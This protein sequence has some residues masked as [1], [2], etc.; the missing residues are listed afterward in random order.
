MK[1]IEKLNYQ[2]NIY[3]K[4]LKGKSIG[5]IGF[6]V[7]DIR[8]SFF[9]SLVNS[10]ESLAYAKGLNVIIC[11]AEHQADKEKLHLD[12]LL[13][14]KIDGLLITPVDSRVAYSALQNRELPFVQIDRKIEKYNS[15]FVGIDYYK[16][17][18]EATTLLLGH[19]SRSPAFI[20]YEDRVYTMENMVRGFRDSCREEGRLDEGR[21]KRICYRD[22]SLTNTIRNW[23]MENKPIDS[24]VCGSE[25]I[26]YAVLQVIAELNLNIPE[27]VIVLSFDDCRW[28]DSLKF[29]ILS[30]QKPISLIAER[31]FEIFLSCMEGKSEGATSDILEDCILIDRLATFTMHR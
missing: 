8:E 15:P 21:I 10:I 2:P 19:G 25:N 12:V 30:L 27:D 23:W 17:A 20:G 5:L 29:P 14:K 4:S 26:C 13:R 7:S 16:Y 11:D 31:S 3:A 9:N 18:R 1:C 22:L 6:I 24:I 28:F